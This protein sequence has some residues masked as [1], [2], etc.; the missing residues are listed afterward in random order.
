MLHNF[1]V[2]VAKLLCKCCAVLCKCQVENILVSL[3]KL[4]ETAKFCAEVTQILS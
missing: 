4:V 3:L 1:Y 2:G